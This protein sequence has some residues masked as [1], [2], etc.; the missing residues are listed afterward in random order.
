MGSADRLI[1]V[2]KIN[3]GERIQKQAS[4]MTTEP[5]FLTAQIHLDI[6]D[7]FFYLFENS[8]TAPMKDRFTSRALRPGSGQARPTGPETTIP[9][10]ARDDA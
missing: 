2:E 8:F 5:G 7:P 9:S 6:F 10:S 3:C 1:D 4:R